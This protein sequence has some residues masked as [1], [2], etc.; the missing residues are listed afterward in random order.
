MSL[1]ETVA[2][3]EAARGSGTELLLSQIAVGTYG[4]L[5]ENVACRLI[6]VFEHVDPL[7]FYCLR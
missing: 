3:R 2:K 4:G 5:S 6:Y 1:R 7:W